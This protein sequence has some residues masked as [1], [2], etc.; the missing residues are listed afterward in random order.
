M[1]ESIGMTL[2]RNKTIGI[3]RH[4]VRSSRDFI[5]KLV[6][7]PKILLRLLVEQHDCLG[8]NPSSS[9]SEVMKN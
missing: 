6:Y 7:V 1:V 8:E 5:V 2:A 3:K 9:S 4:L